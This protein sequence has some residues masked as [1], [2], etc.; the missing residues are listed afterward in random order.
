MILL[1]V[2]SDNYAAEEFNSAWRVLVTKLNICCKGTFLV[3]EFATKF[4][5]W[6]VWFLIGRLICALV[7]WNMLYKP[8]EKIIWKYLPLTQII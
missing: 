7:N 2:K 4:N 8:C 6:E 3:W 5:L 1:V